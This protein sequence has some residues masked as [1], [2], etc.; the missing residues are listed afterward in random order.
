MP[1][2]LLQSRLFLLQKSIRLSFMVVLGSPPPVLERRSIDDP[3]L[4]KK[5]ELLGMIADHWAH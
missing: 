5:V 4:K 1:S 2:M 3:R